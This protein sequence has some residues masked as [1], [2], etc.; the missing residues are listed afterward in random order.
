VR[1]DSLGADGK[2]AGPGL[3]L[4]VRAAGGPHEH[5]EQSK[6]RDTVEAAAE[7]PGLLKLVG[8]GAG[9][10][11]TATKADQT[12]LRDE[13]LSQMPSDP[14]CGELMRAEV[15]RREHFGRR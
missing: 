4:E 8:S 11:S 9:D 12:A 1:G 3:E 13:S 7:T 2:P 10:E 15:G 6:K 14:P 5:P